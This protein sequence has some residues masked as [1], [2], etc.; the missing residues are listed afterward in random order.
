VASPLPPALKGWPLVGNYT[1]YRRDRLGLFRRAYEELGPIFSIRLGPQRAVVLI[2]PEYHRFFFE[3]ADRTL[4]LPEVYQFVVPMFGGVLNAA[5][6]E[7]TRQAH[8]ALLHAAFRGARMQG[9]IEVMEREISNWLDALGEAGEFEMY[10]TF[11]EVGM[12]IAA[13][14]FLGPDV[15]ERMTEF[16]PHF[17]DLALGM[18]FVLPPNLPL[19]RF[20][21]R[22]EARRRLA[23]MI[24]PAIAAR[25]AR[26]DAGDDFL[27]VLLQTEG[28]EAGGGGDE[29]VV[30]LA[31]MTVF[32]GYI[33]TAAQTCW[34]LIQL[35]QHPAYLGLVE[36]ERE[37]VLGDDPVGIDAGAL[38][39]LEQLDRALRESQR[40]H[41]VMSHYAR[42]NAR[43]YELG[44][45][46]VPQ[47]WMTMVCP[48]VAHRLPE[49]FPDP[50]R[51]DPDR[52]APGRA[53]DSGGPYRL[54]GFG[55]GPYRCPGAGFGMNEMKCILT[56]LL[57]RFTLELPRTDPGVA[58]DMGVTRP[59]PPFRMRY[60]QK[61]AP[62]RPSGRAPG[63][64]PRDGQG[65]QPEVE[66]RI[67]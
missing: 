66:V 63:S 8:L 16:S 36:E 12:K 56:L 59:R 29:R 25:R 9:Y 27:R 38:Q 43:P 45:Y 30:G 10:E 1:E 5:R 46:R 37:R 4:S 19:P 3:E 57:R 33:A 24:R 53:E 15:R 13:S 61:P 62:R 23:A 48:A 64:R 14:A 21:R 7:R 6:D 31:L 28:K 58:F 11:A 39:R 26:P 42:Y 35:L 41:P 2:G 65:E 52:F 60:R 67:A 50:D 49:V 54:I 17:H 44:G 34:S 40:M 32:T 55:A 47:G 20:R 51:Y 18:D 22:D